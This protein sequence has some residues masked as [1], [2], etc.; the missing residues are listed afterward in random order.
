MEK[1]KWQERIGRSTDF[2]IRI[3]GKQHVGSVFFIGSCLFNLTLI[4]HRDRVAKIGIKPHGNGVNET[5][6]YFAKCSTDTQE[7]P[8][9][10]MTH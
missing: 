10:F 4:F 5:A 2:S 8:G 3:P 9:N 6:D 7:K 1:G